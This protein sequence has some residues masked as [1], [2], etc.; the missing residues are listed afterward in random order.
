[1]LL[2]CERSDH[3]KLRGKCWLR[4]HHQHYQHHQHQHH[5][6]H[7]YHHHRRRRRRRHYHYEHYHHH[8][9]NQVQLGQFN[10]VKEILCVKRLVNTSGKYRKK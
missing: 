10:K 3:L 8:H 9:H 2:L 1:M 5:H 7:H 6:H 4:H